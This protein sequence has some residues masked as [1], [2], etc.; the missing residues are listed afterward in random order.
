MTIMGAWKAYGSAL[1]FAGAICLPVSMWL[2]QTGG[3]DRTVDRHFL[4]LVMASHFVASA[5]SK[6]LV[7]GRLG[8]ANV[9]N[10]TTN[11]LWTSPCKTSN[12]SVDRR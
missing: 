6:K 1:S 7:Y 8:S 3:T 10:M 4:R 2:L 11:R 5:I 9:S 12:P